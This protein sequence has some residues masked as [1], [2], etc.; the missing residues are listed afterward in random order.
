M[1][2][3]RALVSAVGT[4]RRNRSVFSD[5]NGAAIAVDRRRRGVDDGDFTAVP[6]TPRLIQNV[7][8]AG[9]V[10]LVRV[11]PLAVRT[12][13]RGNCGQVETG[14]NALESLFDS[15]RIGYVPVQKL[16][17]PRQVLSVSARQIIGNAYQVPL[18]Q[19]RVD[20]VGAQKASTTRPE[21]ADQPRT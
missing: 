8:G 20:H 19:K 1:Q 9:E 21:L 12:H 16:D 7:E 11:Q 14:I 2:L 13:D 6:Q 15:R 3:T 18:P 5:R 17:L 4:Q 10:D